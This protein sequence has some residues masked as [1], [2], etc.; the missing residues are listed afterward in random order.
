MRTYRPVKCSCGRPMDP[1][2]ENLLGTE[3]LEYCPICEKYVV[4]TWTKRS[5]VTKAAAFRLKA[6]WDK[7]NG[8]QPHE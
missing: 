4:R 3:W 5:N 2:V 6:T 1:W 7:I 8:V